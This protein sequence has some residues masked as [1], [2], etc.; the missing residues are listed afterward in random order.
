MKRKLPELCLNEC[1][2]HIKKGATKY[3]SL[4]CQF[5]FEYKMRV[6]LLRS[7]QYPACTTTGGNRFVQRFLR[8]NY[9]D[10]CARCGWS[11]VHPITGRVPLEVEHIDGDWRNTRL[12]NL[13]LLCPNCH[14]LTPTYR[15]LNKGKGR[16]RRLGGRDNPLKEAS[17]VC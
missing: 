4:R 15:A 6:E 7:G 8:E 12:D 5:D 2:G 10:K 14:S 17:E 11:Q 1:G 3:C 16:S 13:T 9:G